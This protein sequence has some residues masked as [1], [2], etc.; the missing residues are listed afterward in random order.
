MGAFWSYFIDFFGGPERGEAGVVYAGSAHVSTDPAALR[1][2]DFWIDD[3][4]ETS[5]RDTWRESR[6]A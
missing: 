4:D 3:E 2:A 5:S 6:E 1:D